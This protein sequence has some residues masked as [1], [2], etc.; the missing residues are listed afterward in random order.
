MTVQN[1]LLGLGGE[2]QIGGDVNLH[3]GAMLSVGMTNLPQ[4]LTVQG[5]TR[6]TNATLILNLSSATTPGAGVNDLLDLQG[7]EV[8][9]A[10]RIV[11]SPLEP[12]ATGTPYRV[13]Q[14]WTL[15]GG[16]TVSA[17]APGT[18]YSVAVDTL[19]PGE[20]HLIVSGAASNL[21]WAGVNRRWN[22]TNSAAWAAG[23]ALE[24]FYTLDSV[25]F[26]DS[27][28]GGF[29][30][31]EE[32]VRAWAI[33]VDGSRSYTWV[34][35]G[36]LEGAADLVKRNSGVLMLQNTNSGI[37]AV[38]VEDGT[39]VTIHDR[40]LGAEN[41]RLYVTNNATWDL[42][43][44]ANQF[45]VVTVS[46]EGVGGQGAIVNNGSGN[47]SA[48]R[49]LEIAGDV[50]LGGYQRWDVRNTAGPGFVST[51]NSPFNVTKVGPSQVSF[52]SVQVDTNLADIVIREGI[53]A[54][55][56][57]SAA[58]D[59]SRYLIVHSNA[60]L[61]LWGTQ[62]L[63]KQFIFFGG[64][65][66]FTGSGNEAQDHLQNS[67][68]L[69]NGIALAD[70]NSGHNW[71]FSAVVGGD[72][73]LLTVNSGMVRFN[74]AV[75]SRGPLIAQSG[76]LVIQSNAVANGPSALVVRGS[77][78][79]LVDYGRVNIADRIQDSTPIVLA[80]PGTFNLRGP[81][82]A[83]QT[84]TVG[85]LVLL[86]GPATLLMENGTGTA[87][88]QLNFSGQALQQGSL[89]VQHTGAGALGH[90]DGQ[91]G[92]RVFVAGLADGFVPWATW[93]STNFMWY[94]S[95]RGLTSMVPPAVEFDGTANQ[96]G[97]HVK[98]TANN[99]TYQ[100]DDNRSVESLT[101]TP[102]GATQS[103]DV[104]GNTLT[105]AQGGVLQNGNTVFQ[106][107]DTSG[108][109][110]ITAGGGTLW[111]NVANAAATM[112]VSAVIGGAEFSKEGAGTMILLSQAA[113]TN[114][115]RI[116]GGIL[117][118]GNNS[119]GGMVGPGDVVNYGTLLFHRSDDLTF[120]NP[121]VGGGNVI[122][123][124]VNTITFTAPNTYTG[125]TVIGRGRV[126][127]DRISDEADSNLGVAR[128]ER[129]VD[130]YLGIVDGELQVN[131]SGTSRTIRT[132]YVNE[133]SGMK[134]VTVGATDGVLRF[135][136]QVLGGGAWLKKDG[137]G[138]LVLGGSSAENTSLQLLVASGHVDLAKVT[139]ANFRAMSKLALTNDTTARIIGN[140]GDQI[141]GTL[142]LWTN[143]VLDLN[144]QDETID[145]L[146][147]AE[148]R[149]I[150]NAAARRASSR[151]DGPTGPAS[152]AAQLRT[153]WA[154]WR[155]T[156]PARA[157][158]GSRTVSVPIPAAR[159]FRM[160][161]SM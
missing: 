79:I 4:T 125:F 37:G 63:N 35:Y 60:T 105:V 127:V 80:G 81:T 38:R 98:F 13:V 115:T 23:S 24:R 56:G 58:G 93:F 161:R 124:N 139:F 123:T 59:P 22:L 88:L 15:T 30:G 149:V 5:T 36:G 49:F 87:C 27:Q 84:E 140:N 146:Q 10:N 55:E 77:G 66:L 141:Y 92:S 119:T 143:A 152:T 90:L 103:L 155:C 132:V 145:I 96:S 104:W 148:G 136:G 99:S 51:L 106:I 6:A 95:A 122:K 97:Q 19:T 42:R 91:S 126:V 47:I 34:G 50:T 108:G 157:S 18:R 144:G 52:V 43:G 72:G 158:C 138:T 67:V 147:G 26:D 74:E 14:Y 142:W 3:H 40:T 83:T 48:L 70:V 110:Q 41:T 12:L 100:L 29:V 130:S 129:P 120:T 16:G 135:D 31:I 68:V 73:G 131:G 156:R 113:T 64:A 116:G 46:G 101:I 28:R 82:N 44:I 150:N 75:T 78:R 86:G 45:R 9:G 7:L 65:R 39:L 2:G 137:P 160:G 112:R 71:N 94:S 8:V 1:G 111:F 85:D 153:A 32:S 118:L 109:G 151:L 121:I 102:A 54:L 133:G 128:P 134:V 57:S 114:R 154:W 117:Q 107:S 17:D 53:F 11:V 76:V 62:P 21:V 69:T 25:T 159:S 20:V 61:Q 89:V 33:V